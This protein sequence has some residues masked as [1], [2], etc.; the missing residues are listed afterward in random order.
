MQDPFTILSFLSPANPLI[1]IDHAVIQ[2]M[3]IIIIFYSLP[4][5]FSHRRPKTRIIDQYPQPV[6]KGIHVF[7][8][9]QKTG[10]LICDELRYARMPG[11]DDGNARGHRLFEYVGDAFLVAVGGGDAGCKQNVA[12]VNFRQNLLVRFHARHPDVIGIGG[13][14]NAEHGEWQIPYGAMVPQTVDNVLAAGRCISCDLRMADLVRLIPNCFV[15]G[16]AAGVAAAVAVR[17][18]CKPRDADITEIQ[19]ILRQQEAYLG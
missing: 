16:H 11:T 17:D 6:L 7:F 5:G 15:T 3:D 8:R 10:L 12:V 9:H 1:K 19:K 18:Q 13:A 2:R 14:S 4:S